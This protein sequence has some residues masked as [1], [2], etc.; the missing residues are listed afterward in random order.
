MLQSDG[1]LSTPQGFSADGRL[2]RPW[3]VY[4]VNNPILGKRIR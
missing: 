1:G 3:L 4:D 2:P